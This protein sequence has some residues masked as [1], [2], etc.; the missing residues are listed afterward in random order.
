MTREE[1]LNEL[2]SSI[3]S[4][5]SDEQAEAIQY[6][7]DYFDEAADDEKVMRELG[8]PSELAKT[9]IEKFANALV[10]TK[11]SDS[12][13]ASGDSESGSY[14]YDARSI[15][16]LYFEFEKSK[17][18]SLSVDIGAAECVIIEGSKYCI[19]TRGL[20]QESLNCYLNKEGGLVVSNARRFNLNFWSHDRRSRIVPRILL[21]VPKNAELDKLRIAVG[22]GRLI[23]KTLSVHCESGNIDVGAGNLVLDG[24]FGGRVDMRCGMG[25]FE[26]NGSVSGNINLDCGMGS[27]E[28]NLK[29]NPNDYSYDAKV[30]LGYFCF[31]GEQRSG[32]CKVYNNERKQN[33]FSVNCGMGSVEVK[34]HNF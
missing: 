27:V 9:I 8:T 20:L 34:I 10:D 1:Y 4:L 31:N 6:Y 11:N 30:G 23:S 17:V 22:A 14:G 7:S 28:L 15:D 3:M 2:K 21:T 32:V 12:E 18:K 33:H 24:I 13:G 5:T 16:A 25:N 29:G 19:E 26:L